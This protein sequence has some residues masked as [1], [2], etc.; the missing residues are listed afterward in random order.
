MIE[1]AVESLPGN[2]TVELGERARLSG[3]GR[4]MCSRYGTGE[5]ERRRYRR[6]IGDR[7]PDRYTIA[8]HEE[9]LRRGVPPP[10]IDIDLLHPGPLD[11][12]DDHDS[13]RKQH[14]WVVGLLPEPS[15]DCPDL[16]ELLVPESLWSI[17]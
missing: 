2:V 16:R 3:L 13:V 6:I 17:S 8:V 7:R 4:R 11:F 1:L 14:E 12:L 10:S 5:R 9:F 15:R